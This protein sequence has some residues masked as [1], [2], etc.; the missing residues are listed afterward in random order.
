MHLHVH[1]DHLLYD[2]TELFVYMLTLVLS[3][4]THFWIN[5]FVDSITTYWSTKDT[6][7]GT[8]STWLN[9]VVHISVLLL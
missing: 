7:L 2:F 8:N 4:K 5:I 6:D 9:I 1:I 3:S